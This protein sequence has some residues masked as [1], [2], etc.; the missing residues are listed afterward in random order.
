MV[1][2]KVITLPPIVERLQTTQGAVYDARAARYAWCFASAHTDQWAGDNPPPLNIICIVTL[3]VRKGSR[4]GGDPQ[5]WRPAVLHAATQTHEACR[6]AC[7]HPNT[8][9]TPQLRSVGIF[10]STDEHTRQRR[11]LISSRLVNRQVA[12]LLPRLVGAAGT[13]KRF[14]L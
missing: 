12:E 4:A 13:R 9:K 2:Q 10:S 1:G 7:C 11:R 5:A 3:R 6:T 8:H 14:R